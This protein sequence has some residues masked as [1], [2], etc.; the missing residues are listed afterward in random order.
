MEA[1]QNFIFNCN[2]A[3]IARGGQT[4]FS[5][6]NIEFDI[7]DFLKNEPAVGPE[8]VEVGVYGDY[9]EE[10]KYRMENVLLQ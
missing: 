3:L 6:I 10:P 9:E 4:I 5:S 1:I 2:C 8:G 7:P